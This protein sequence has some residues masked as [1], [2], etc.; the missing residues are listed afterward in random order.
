M[1]H[2][3]SFFSPPICIPPSLI[4]RDYLHFPNL[5]R[6]S[7]AV[8]MSPDS[9]MFSPQLILHLLPL[10]SKEFSQVPLYWGE[11][12]SRLKLLL[13]I[14]L[15]PRSR[16]MLSPCL[17]EWGSIKVL[18][19]PSFASCPPFLRFPKHSTSPGHH[20]HCPC[21]VGDICL[22]PSLTA[23]KS[24]SPFIR[25]NFYL[26]RCISLSLVLFPSLSFKQIK[27]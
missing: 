12:P 20:P 3:P 17:R 2:A 4:A 11:P 9:S 5:L 18:W 25:E 7:W 24:L 1:L 14:S 15:G 8:Q 21:C 6:H 13:C 19:L 22:A 10:F 26:S 27:K 23:S 16:W